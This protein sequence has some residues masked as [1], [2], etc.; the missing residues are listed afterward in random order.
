LSQ[1]SAPRLRSPIERC[2][3]EEAGIGRRVG[4]CRLLPSADLAEQINQGLIRF[5]GFRRVPVGVRQGRRVPH[6]CRGRTAQH[7]RRGDHDPRGH[8]WGRTGFLARGAR[9]TAH[10][11]WRARACPGRLVSA[12]RG[13]FLYYP[14]RRQQPAALSALI[15]TLRLCRDSCP[16]V[17][18]PFVSRSRI[19]TPRTRFSVA[20]GPFCSRRRDPEDGGRARRGDHRRRR[21]RRHGVNTAYRL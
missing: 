9:G 12:V 18:A 21:T 4:R 10:R 7:R 1:P 13:F 3:S 11:K 20:Q 16:A 19:S 17:A 15:E 2:N 8:R 5:P 6:G 14:S